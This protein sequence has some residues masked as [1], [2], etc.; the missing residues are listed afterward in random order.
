[1]PY[2]PK[3]LPKFFY[4]Y[5]TVHG[6][7]YQYTEPK[8][9]FLRTYIARDG[10][11][12]E[13]WFRTNPSTDALWRYMKIVERTLRRHEG[14][15]HPLRIR[16]FAFQVWFSA[17]GPTVQPLYL[18]KYKLA[19]LNQMM[20]LVNKYL[21]QQNKMPQNWSRDAFYLMCCYLTLAKK[22]VSDRNTNGN[23]EDEGLPL[24]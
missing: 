7:P 2:K 6:V 18:M 21:I 22:K 1:M 20:R 15:K 11:K 9:I 23:Q 5:M 16:R 8:A 17:F 19:V 12:R 14:S 13:K 3:Y 24:L 10:T 4:R